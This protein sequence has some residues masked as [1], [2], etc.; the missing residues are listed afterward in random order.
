MA[1]DITGVSG[2]A[3]LEA[4]IGGERSPETLAQ[5]ARAR[6]R[7]KIPDLV[8]ALT[9]HFSDHH[10]FVCRMHLDHYDHLTSQIKQVSDRSEEEIAPFQLQ[11]SRL[12]TIPGVS[13]RVA[14]AIVAETGAD[15][16]RFPS[17]GHLASWAGVCPGNNESGGRRKSGR[18]RHG[19]RWLGGAL[20][21]AAMAAARTK[22]ITYLGALYRRLAGRWGKKRALV[23]VEHSMLVSVWHMLTHDGDYADLGGSYFLQLDPDRAARQAVQRLHQLGFQV[24]LNPREAA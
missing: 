9:G 8:E 2:R 11:L 19:N 24:T 5:M 15:M 12:E 17:A 1:T 13:R 20:G 23:A 3:M 4:L 6:M 22:D 10:G 18:T 7:T 14:E 21:T 16:T